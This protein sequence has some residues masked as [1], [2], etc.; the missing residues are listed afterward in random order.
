[1]RCANETYRSRH[2]YVCSHLWSIEESSALTRATIVDTVFGFVV[3][4]S[5][6]V[7]VS[8][9]TKLRTGSRQLLFNS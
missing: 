6:G 7:L 2:V 1:M 4:L 9:L 8:W 3:G 5:V